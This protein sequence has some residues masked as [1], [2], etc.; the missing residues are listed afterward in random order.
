MSR[1]P[2]APTVLLKCDSLQWAW[3]TSPSSGA[4]WQEKEMH[5][6]RGDPQ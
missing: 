2:V 3:V 5:N 6:C 4:L 1:L